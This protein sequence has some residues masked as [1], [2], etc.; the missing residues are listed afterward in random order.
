M[1]YEGDFVRIS[2]QSFFRIPTLCSLTMSNK[3]VLI[4]IGLGDFP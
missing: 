1:C 2:E 4:N 3:F